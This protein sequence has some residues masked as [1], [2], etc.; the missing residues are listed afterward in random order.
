M[1]TV[2]EG[3]VWRVGE[4]GDKAEAGGDGCVFVFVFFFLWRFGGGGGGETRTRRAVTGAFLFV[5]LF[6]NI[7]KPGH[8]D[9]AI[10]QSILVH[11]INYQ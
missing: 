2:F 7:L 6:P 5:F 1:T 9:Y 8:R 3:P 4:G 11:I 10:N